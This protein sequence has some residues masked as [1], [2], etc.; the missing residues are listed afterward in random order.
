MSTVPTIEGIQPYQLWVFFY[1]LM[2]LFGVIIVVDKVFDI[3]KKH[4]RNN[5][6]TCEEHARVLGDRITNVETQTN[7]V[8]HEI[9]SIHEKLDNDNRRL[10]ALENGQV[11]IHS[12]FTA[13]CT[14][15]IALLDHGLKDD[16]DIEKMQDAKEKLMS[17]LMR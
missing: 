8:A 5:S 12:G 17:Y 7:N 1:V 15:I 9:S 13:L 3:F 2:A 16:D 11:D 14:A 6:Q 10:N 4:K